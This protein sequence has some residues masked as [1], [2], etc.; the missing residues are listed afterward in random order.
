M[1]TTQGYTPVGRALAISAGGRRL[2]RSSQPSKSRPPAGV[3]GINGCVTSRRGITEI[4]QTLHRHGHRDGQGKSLLATCP[5]S[6]ASYTREKAAAGERMPTWRC[7]RSPR[8]LA[9][10]AR[11]S[12]PKLVVKE[13][14]MAPEGYGISWTGCLRRESRRFSAR[15][16]RPAGG[17]TSR[18]TLALF[19]PFRSSPRNGPRAAPRRNLRPSLLVARTNRHYGRAGFTG[20]R[21]KEG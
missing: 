9:L 1:R 20:S 8:G 6:C 19:R 18:A 17:L 2:P 16:S 12:L 14:A 3:A 4:A 5:R 11:A 21:F 15:N 13:V 7:L 10:R